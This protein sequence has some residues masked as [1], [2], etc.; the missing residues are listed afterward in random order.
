MAYRPDLVLFGGDYIQGGPGVSDTQA[1]AALNRVIQAAELTAPLGCFAVRGN[2]DL[3]EPWQESF[4]GTGVRT[5]E[6]TTNIDSGELDVLLLSYADSL[7]T[8]LALG[9][10]PGFRIVV[11]HSPDFA[12][13]TARADLLLA[14]HTH[15]G[16]VRLPFI[17]PILTLSRV[18]RRWA[19][20]VTEL[21][22]SA[23]LIVPHGVGMERR[24]APRMRF[25]CPPE[26]YIIDIT[27]GPR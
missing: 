10:R 7:R 9:P 5:C 27:P 25:L 24:H 1:R 22:G 13:G 4:A 14:G 20:G 19:S 16:Q 12:L 23:T 8:D 2:I 15:G 21:P 18:R 17:G 11:G 26:V 6:Q 3:H